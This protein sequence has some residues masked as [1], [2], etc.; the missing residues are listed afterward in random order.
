MKKLSLLL[1]G[2]T[3]ALFIGCGNKAESTG[4]Q[5]KTIDDLEGAR[6][7]VQLGTIG[8]IYASDYE[9][10]KAG[11]TIDRYNKITDAVQALKQGKLDCVIVDEQPAI[12]TTKD[13]QP[14]EDDRKACC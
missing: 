10:D 2:L 3:A 7:G 12:A 9:G 6:I 13:G 5:V 8:D 14:A 11:T 1:L 4:K